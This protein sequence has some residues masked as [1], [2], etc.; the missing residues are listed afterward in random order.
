MMAQG[1]SITNLF[2]QTPP[3][4][5]QVPEFFNPVRYVINKNWINMYLLLNS[6]YQFL[7]HLEINGFPEHIESTNTL[8]FTLN[9]VML[10]SA[11][12]INGNNS[13]D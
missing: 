13:T 7:Y 11:N 4:S 6:D 2:V 5:N 1:Y 10:H 9:F 3:L 12:I 8:P